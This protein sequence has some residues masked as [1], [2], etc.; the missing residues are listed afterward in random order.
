MVWFDNVVG[1]S[2]LTQAP[3]K[4]I[5]STIR[6]ICG[7]GGKVGFELGQEQRLGFSVTDFLQL[8]DN[9]KEF[10]IV[11]AA[12]LLLRLRMIKTDREVERIRRM[13]S[14]GAMGAWVWVIAGDYQRIDGV[15]RNKKVKEG[16][17][18]FIDMG[19]NFCGYWADFSRAGV[20]GGPTTEQ[21]KMQNLIGEVCNIGVNA[22]RIGRTMA[23][24]AKIVKKAMDDR[25]L[26]FNSRADRYG[27]GMGLFTTEPPSVSPYD[28][29]IIEANM[30]LTME[31]G[32]FRKDGMFH[33]EENFL[34]TEAGPEVLSTPKQ[35]LTHISV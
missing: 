24:V 13:N 28:H 21:N 31:P 16:D 18:I 27:H 25:E 33:L 12:D 32:M 22:C 2:D 15:T 4:E 6:E 11:D 1:Y 14:Y 29:T 3:V 35:E 20:L 5:A 23:Q 10:E 17:L 34:I 19:A 26:T 30:V 8:R 7:S 9:L